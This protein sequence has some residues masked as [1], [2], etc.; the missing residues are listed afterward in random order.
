MVL[1]RK[2]VKLAGGDD[3]P[4]PCR[5]PLEKKERKMKKERDGER[6]GRKQR[7]TSSYCPHQLLQRI[8][9]F[10]LGREENKLVSLKAV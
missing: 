1:R 2:K 10:I 9:C 4:D 7:Q 5:S 8:L 6:E 3:P